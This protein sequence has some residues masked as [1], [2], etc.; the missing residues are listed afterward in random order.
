MNNVPPHN[1][2]QS[3]E[4]IE[5][6]KN[7]D[8]MAFLNEHFLE[9]PDLLSL[10][11]SGKVTFNI[12][13]LTQILHLYRKAKDKI[14]LW[15]ENR[16][17]M[18]DKSYAQSSHWEVAQFKSTLFNGKMLLDLTGG[19]GV[20]SY[21]FSFSFD[22]VISVERDLTT[23][24]FA[25][26]NAAK[27]GA[28]NIQFIQADS[29][30]FAFDNHYDVIYVD[31]DRRT[32]TSRILGD[33]EA[34]SPNIVEEHKKWL[35]HADSVVV[36][37]SPMVDLTLLEKTFPNLKSIY[38]IGHKNEVKEILI[39]LVKADVETAKKYSVNISSANRVNQYTSDNYHDSAATNEYGSFLL[40]PS[41]PLIK[42]GLSHAYCHQVGIHPII[43]KGYYYLHDASIPDFDGRQF[44][45]IEMLDGNWKSIK[46]YFKSEGIKS[47]EIAQRHFFDDV[48]TIRQKLNIKAGGNTSL[49]FTVNSEG[50]SL[51][52]HTKRITET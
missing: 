7:E 27:L 14:P 46:K 20:D 45:I 18:H 13:K 15:V 35:Q 51:C 16:C 6:L 38:V 23:H 17:A 11:Y 48:A 40:E 24:Q 12:T 28:H 10:K 34:Y 39:H 47:I 22:F 36:K 49:H 19:L 29:N 41:K 50:K 5:L 37:L 4:I 1:I 2:V 43:P 42:S 9:S 32:D 8:A 52:F 25:L 26:Y 30:A 31:P 33:I 3:N 44:E 21:Y